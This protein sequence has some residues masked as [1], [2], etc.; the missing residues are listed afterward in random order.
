MCKT[1]VYPGS[2]DP[3]TNGHLDIIVRA[4]KIFDEVV[5]AVFVNPNKNPTFTMEQRV[6]MLEEITKD[7][8]NV[9]VDCFGGLLT[10][11][12]QNLKAKT[13]I[14]GL[15]ALSDFE[16]EFQQALMY[17]KLNPDVEIMFLMTKSD[18]GFLSSS[19]IKE[20]ASLN[21]KIDDLVPPTVAKF[22]KEHFNN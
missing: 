21:G 8:P 1:A 19:L 16:K 22:L 5:V 18:Y 7:M 6:T 3:I 14:R 20:I 13:I 2:F 15:R 10:D 12:A 9:R 11:Y 17:K 4:T